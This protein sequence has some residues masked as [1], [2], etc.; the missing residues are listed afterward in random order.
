[1]VDHQH[2]RPPAQSGA[3]NL[4]VARVASGLRQGPLLT[5]STVKM[6]EENEYWNQCAVLVGI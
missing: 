5:F 2:G 1:L 4:L 3:V 6:R